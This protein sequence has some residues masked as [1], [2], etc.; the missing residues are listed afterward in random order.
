MSSSFEEVYRQVQQNGVYNKPKRPVT[1]L[2]VVDAQND[3][4]PGGPLG[5][6]GAV[7]AF[8]ATHRHVAGSANKYKVLVTTRDDHKDPGTHWS[9]HPDFV[10]TWPV[11]CA[12]GTEGADFHPEMKR[13]LALFESLNPHA[14]RI[15]VT[16]G[17]QEAAYSGF[18]GVTEAG[19]SLLDALQA[20]EVEQLDVVGV[21]TD[22]CVLATAMDGVK[23][24]FTVRVLTK[25]IAA[26]DADRG[27]KAL[28]Q[29]AAAG[30]EIVEA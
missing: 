4:C 10:D 29:L 17:A 19:V 11:H 25:Q 5:V 1:A 12:H 28:E 22:H 6:D 7:E 9:D 3:F 24:G 14:V 16:K 8:Q 27:A 21:A 30:A 23:A 15:D 26:V 20:S 13:A 2:V 18:E